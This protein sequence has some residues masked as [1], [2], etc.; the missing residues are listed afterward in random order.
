MYRIDEIRFTHDWRNFTT[1]TIVCGIGRLGPCSKEQVI[2]YLK[3]AGKAVAKSVSQYFLGTCMISAKQNAAK[4]RISQFVLDQ[5]I[6]MVSNN[7]EYTSM[8]IW[9]Q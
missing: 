8:Q 7:F 1:L 2:I 9:L 5:Y 6:K 4:V 3:M